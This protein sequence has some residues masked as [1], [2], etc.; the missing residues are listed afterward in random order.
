MIPQLVSA[1]SLIKQ[2]SAGGLAGLEDSRWPPIMWHLVMAIGRTASVFLTESSSSA[3]R[4]S[5]D[6]LEVAPVARR[7]SCGACGGLHSGTHTASHSPHS[8]GLGQEVTHI[9]EEGK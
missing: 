7:W 1:G 3:G 4:A 9:Q 8:F 2:H 5:E 6:S